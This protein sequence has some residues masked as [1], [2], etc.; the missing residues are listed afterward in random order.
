MTRMIR[1]SVLLAACVGLWSC[2][3]DP[4]ADEA[5]VPFKVIA[6][7]SVVFI[8][9][10]SSQ[11]ISFQL[12]DEFDGQIPENWTFTTSSPNFTV[13]M[14]S[15]YRPVYNPDGTLTLPEQQTEVRVTITGA[16]LGISSFTASA[17][18]KSLVVP[19]NVVPGN[20]YATFSPANPNPG[21]TVTMT[22]PATLRLSPTSAVTFPGNVAPIIIDR[23]AD[24]LSL[25]FINA[26]TTDTTAVVTLVSNAEFPTIAPVTLTTKDKVTGSQS[27]T[28]DGKLP[29]TLSP[30]VAGQVTVT[31]NSAYSF[32]CDPTCANA[33][34][35]VFTFPTQTA[36]IVSSVSADSTVAV[37]SVGPNVASPLQATRVTFKGAPQF[38]YTLVSA[39]SVI[40]P[41]IASLPA[42]LSVTNPQ[43]G[44]PTVLTAG[45]GF[46]FAATATAT[47]PGGGTAVVVSRTASTLTLQPWPGSSGQP[48]VTGVIAASAPAF[49]LT[50]PATL[51][52]ALTMQATAAAI[53]PIAGTDAFATAPVLSVG[54]VGVFDA[55]SFGC[56]GCGVNGFDSQIYSLTVP[57]GSRTFTLIYSN[58]SDLGLYFQTVA[59][60]G[61][62]VTTGCDAHGNG[63]GAQPETC[64]ATFPAGT[65]F[66]NVENFAPAYPDPDPIWIALRFN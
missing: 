61:P 42:T 37:L 56:V 30:L 22:M 11:L 26:P 1:G 8:K 34:P 14:D 66:L 35:T 3:S 18:G 17:G 57:A 48:T 7:P 10:D 44:E 55:A 38:E 47:F 49:Q 2:S 15:S 51:P 52:T 19:V 12:V 53:P 20:L 36:P 6:L 62:V 54:N 24:S 27:G 45:A 31:L 40:S 23:A 58:D 59:G 32:K 25:R 29:A 33:S 9:Q 28:W 60:G 13:A 4:T 63:A 16:A 43:I 39:D 41:V 21:D 50:L 46:T 64:T 5:G 65:Y